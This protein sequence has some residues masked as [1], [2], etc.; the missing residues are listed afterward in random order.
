MV[1]S[2]FFLSIIGFFTKIAFNQGLFSPGWPYS[3]NIDQ[4]EGAKRNIENL[5]YRYQFEK[6]SLLS[7]SSQRI[8]TTQEQA[9][10]AQIEQHAKG[11][12]STK[13]E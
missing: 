1:D 12:E 8:L 3:N 10:L 11:A 9:R 5:P 2:S 7:Q 6:W 13:K 4:W